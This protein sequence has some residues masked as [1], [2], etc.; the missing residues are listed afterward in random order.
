LTR[1]DDR[2]APED[3]SGHRAFIR[4]LTWAVTGRGGAIVAGLGATALLTRLLSPY[5]LGAYY[6]IMA[7]AL[8]ASPVGN[9][10]LDEP[11][12]RTIAA[13]KGIGRPEHAAAFARSSLRLAALSSICTAALIVAIWYAARQF[14]HG[15]SLRSFTVA[16]LMALWTA[17]FAVERQ[18]VATLQG[19]EDIAA[20]SAFDRT[21]GRVLSCGALLALWWS[22]AHATL[23]DILFAVIASEC[24][25]LAGAAV[26]A[27]RILDALG[28]TKERIPIGELLRTA[29]PFMIQVVT[30]TAS[31]QCPIF[32][33][34]TFQSPAE[35]AVYGVATRLSALLST[36]GVAVNV[37]LAPAVARLLS[38][39]KR[40]ELQTVLQF[41]ALVPTLIAIAA[42]VWW[43]FGGHGLLVALFGAPY[44]AGTAV[45]LTLSVSQAVGLF[46]GPSLLILS[47]GG[48]QLL[49]T[50]IS[51][52]NALG[53]IAVMVP[54][55]GRWGA[56]GAAISILLGTFLSKAAG[57]WAV[58][59]RLGVWSQANFTVAGRQW[60]VIAG[61]ARAAVRGTRRGPDA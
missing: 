49:A 27:A 33:L 14:G 48:E 41:A 58:R 5:D 35:V 53:T 39:R 23:T 52:V 32:V 30:S 17:I 8:T 3:H 44:G 46:F 2:R 56:E 9:L 36:P 55:I 34:A 42:V 51:L 12:I 16:L 28:P 45:L 50:K 24:V 22:H 31:Q 19:V 37:P 11:A 47:M 1:T 6:L 7:V 54:L 15:G 60:Q 26:R 21:L 10:S 38:Q 25:S 29:W 43:S 18:L 13:A 59:R 61:V 40:Q 20:A 57:W 4:N